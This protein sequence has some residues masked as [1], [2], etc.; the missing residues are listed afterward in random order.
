MIYSRSA[1]YAIRAFIQLAEV[2]E[3]KYA[4]V[5]NIAEQADIPAHFLAKILQQLARKGFLRSSKGPTGGFCLRIPADE[6]TMLQIVDAVD[7]LTD[8]H[9][10]PAGMAECNDQ[11][12]CGMHDT[13][14][15]LRSRIME[16]LEGTTIEELAQALDQKRR[17]IEKR[18]KSKRPSSRKA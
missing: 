1:E 13:W 8:F 15:A 4:M 17:A 11:M 18:T 9:R 6:I 2:P 3:G 7:G 14:K 12:P 5:K 10:C 16:Y